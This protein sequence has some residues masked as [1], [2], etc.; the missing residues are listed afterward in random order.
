MHAGLEGF[1]CG[2]GG[3][4]YAGGADACLGLHDRVCILLSGVRL[5]LL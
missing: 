5:G 4:F 1:L 2:A 3:G